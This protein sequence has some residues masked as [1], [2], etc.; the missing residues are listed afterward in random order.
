MPETLPRRLPGFRFETRAGL[1]ADVLPR[2]DIG[3]F[4]GFAGAG[5]LDLPVLGHPGGPACFRN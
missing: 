1:P 4:V 3:V 2:M 5:P